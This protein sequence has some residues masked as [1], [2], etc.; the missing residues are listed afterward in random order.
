MDT[1]A[2]IM[3]KPN[4]RLLR[5][6]AL[7]AGVTVLTV[8][9]VLG[10]A[11]LI[12]AERE[13]LNYPLVV[14]MGL[15]GGLALGVALAYM[16]DRY[17]GRLR[18]IADVQAVTDLPVL[19]EVPTMRLEGADRV[20]VATSQ[21]AYGILAADLADAVHEWG[22]HSLL[23]TSPTRG[24]GR[25]TTA[26]SLATLSAG[27]G[28]QVALVSADPNGEGVDEMLGLER[29]PGLT[30]V[31]GGSISLES[32]LQPGGVENLSV[33]T[34]G[35][36]SDE[37]LAQQLDKL[38]QLLDRLAKMFDLVLIDAPAVLGGLETVLLAHE[39]ELLLLVVDVPNGKRSDLAA[40]VA[41]LSHAQ[42]R[43]VGCIANDPGRRGHRA[44]RGG[45]AAAPMAAGSAVLAGLVAVGVGLT[46]LPRR[47]ASAVAAAA[48]AASRTA[49]RAGGAV[50][51]KV[52]SVDR[53]GA[54]R[55][56]RWVGVVAA[57][58]AVALLISAV[59]W[60]NPD[61]D[62]SKAG[63]E[64]AAAHDASVAG[65]AAPSHDAVAAAMTECRSI[66]NA[67]TAPLHAAAAS[68]EQWQVHVS[69]MNQLVAG[70]I[71]LGQAQ[72]FWERTR[73][74]AAQKVRRFHR[75]DRTFAAGQHSCPTLVTSQNPDPDLAAL[76][77]CRRDIAQRDDAL[78]AARV[79][80]GTWQ[81]HVMDMNMLRAGKMSPTRALR[82]WNRYWKQGVAELH[83]YH[84]QLHQT[85]NLHC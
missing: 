37:A 21:P 28:L 30:E 85:D 41:Y 44:A 20:D 54:L 79:G 70:K 9:A 64:T 78:Q 73:V 50:R 18:T 60:A 46:V 29:Q 57:A 16:W 24:A 33:L 1:S 81:H 63:Q 40:A 77:A 61:D 5:R 14:G 51:D 17:S 49:S 71:T 66:W 7:I 12:S 22:A 83:H 72:A 65:I 8:A 43:L 19:A 25:T 4:A 42:D 84:K 6:A 68:L 53:R 11:W 3:G 32:A 38:A 82:L 59:W 58:A 52:H 2:L 23:V 56:H 62:S 76:S 48:G 27:E 45:A 75:A 26:V 35:G 55:R 31:I 47:A 80:I 34:A 13:S 36:S 10:A 74:E 39:A 67:Q 15:V 69:A